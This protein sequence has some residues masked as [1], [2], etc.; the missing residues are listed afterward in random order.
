[1]VRCHISPPESAA[2]ALEDLAVLDS[3]VDGT[4]RGRRFLRSLAVR[5]LGRRLRVLDTLRRHPEIAAVPVPP[6]VDITGPE[7]SGTAD[8][9]GNDRYR[10]PGPMTRLLI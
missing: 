6:I 3:A 7:R 9:L 8:P 4:D 2:A 1:V 5:D 10:C